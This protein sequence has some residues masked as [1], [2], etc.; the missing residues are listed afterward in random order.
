MSAVRNRFNQAA[1]SYQNASC[2]QK[3]IAG[4]LLALATPQGEVL[5]LGC[6]ASRLPLNSV[7]C[8]I[9][10]QTLQG[11]SKA[12]CADFSALPFTNQFDW[13]VSNMALH[14]SHDFS[15]TLAQI[16]AALKPNGSILFSIPIQPSFTKLKTVLK[17]EIQTFCFPE[18]K[19]ILSFCRGKFVI[20]SQ[21]IQKFDIYFDDFKSLSKHFLETGCHIRQKGLWTPKKWQ[22]INQVFKGGITLQYH[23]LLIAMRK[24]G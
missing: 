18:E 20:I 22:R 8:D 15:T 1:R 6:G 13:V 2:V 19:N 14:W 11:Q 10:E 9:A 12:V 3:E 4:Q 23:I 5:D 7:G 24:D 21:Q 17:N 16:H